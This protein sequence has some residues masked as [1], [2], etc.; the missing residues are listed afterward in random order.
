MKTYKREIEVWLW[1]NGRADFDIWHFTPDGYPKI[2]PKYIQIKDTY[3][4]RSNLLLIQDKLGTPEA[5]I[6]PSGEVRLTWETEMPY[7][8]VLDV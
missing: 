4:I 2:P 3:K 1:L 6:I 7:R 5:C 8:E